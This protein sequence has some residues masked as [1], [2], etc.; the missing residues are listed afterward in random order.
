MHREVLYIQ[1]DLLVQALSRSEEATPCVALSFTLLQDKNAR[2]GTV[3]PG[4]GDQG[5]PDAKQELAEGI[6][7][8]EQ[9]QWDSSEAKYR[10]EK[11]GSK[12]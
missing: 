10:T 8:L 11:A 5:V 3:G 4:S 2:R 6:T 1:P 7:G 9:C 12:N